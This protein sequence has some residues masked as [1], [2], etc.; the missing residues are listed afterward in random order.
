M[1]VFHLISAQVQDIAER[2]VVL[3]KAN[4]AILFHQSFIYFKK[5]KKITILCFLGTVSETKHRR[6]CGNIIIVPTPHLHKMNPSLYILDHFI[7]Q[8]N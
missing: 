6:A 8:W 7:Y 4:Y 2:E 3:D 5:F 1:P